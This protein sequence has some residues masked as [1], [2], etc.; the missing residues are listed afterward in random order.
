M[1]ANH[2][3]AAPGRPQDFGLEWGIPS[4]P[5]LT[6]IQ[7]ALPYIAN[8]LGQLTVYPGFER[9]LTVGDI[10]NAIAWLIRSPQ[11]HKYVLV[12]QDLAELLPA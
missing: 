2:R 4:S 5:A 7:A 12:R 11:I 6:L 3:I 8:A 1:R 10:G 9:I